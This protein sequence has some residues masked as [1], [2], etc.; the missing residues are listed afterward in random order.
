MDYGALKPGPITTLKSELFNQL[1]YPPINCTVYTSLSPS[2]Y[3]SLSLSLCCPLVPLKLSSRRFSVQL[4]EAENRIFSTSLAMNCSSKSL[5]FCLS[6]SLSLYCFALLILG[7][8]ECLICVLCLFAVSGEVPEE[9]VVSAKSGLLF[10]K[11]LIERHISVLL[12]FD[13]CF[14]LIL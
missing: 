10:E 1:S 6:I 8:N 13:A 2:P 14:W 4:S 3:P 5:S 9:P 7:F 12:S 11:R